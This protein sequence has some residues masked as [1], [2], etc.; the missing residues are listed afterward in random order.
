MTRQNAWR[1][2]AG[3]D[4]AQA[5]SPRILQPFCH[6]CLRAR[7]MADSRGPGWRSGEGGQEVLDVR[8]ETDLH[9]LLKEMQE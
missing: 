4:K 6:Y 5:K 2:T 1:D 7:K 8:T 9:M 3:R